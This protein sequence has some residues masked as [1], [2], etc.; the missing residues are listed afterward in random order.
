M[1]KVSLVM[2]ILTTVLSS[3]TCCVSHNSN[4]ID[5]A[6][7]KYEQDTCDKTAKKL[8]EEEFDK[9]STIIYWDINC[10]GRADGC[11]VQRY[12]THHHSPNGKIINKYYMPY[13]YWL[14]LN[15]N[16]KPESDEYFFDPREDGLNGNEETEKTLKE[17]L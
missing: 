8:K 2:I 6:I 1:K 11:S 7:K 5:N 17:W 12:S 16:G 4:V 15:K 13:L 9:E 3:G 10:D 14:D